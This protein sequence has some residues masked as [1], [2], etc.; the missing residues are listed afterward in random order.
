AY[1]YKRVLKFKQDLNYEAWERDVLSIAEGLNTHCNALNPLQ[2]N[3]IKATAR[4]VSRWTWKHFDSAT[5][6]DIQSNRG[7][8]NLGKTKRTSAKNKIDNVLELFK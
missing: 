8:R 4:S 7:K 1:A 6:S 5:F 3:E 2:Y